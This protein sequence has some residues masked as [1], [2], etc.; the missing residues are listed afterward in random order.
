MGS[1][2]GKST[3]VVWEYFTKFAPRLNSL[4][5]LNETISSGPTDTAKLQV[6]FWEKL[7]DNL[8]QLAEEMGDHKKVSTFNRGCMDIQQ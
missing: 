3:D 4:Q 6:L 5:K 7:G 1:L 2:V 8:I